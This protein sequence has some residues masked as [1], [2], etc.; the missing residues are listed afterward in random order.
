MKKNIIL[1]TLAIVMVLCTM[2]NLAVPAFAA[3]NDYTCSDYTDCTANGSEIYIIVKDGCPIRE[4][5]HNKGKIVARAEAGQLIAVKRVFWTIK[6]TRWCE[7]ETDSGKSLYVHIDNVEPEV[8]SFITLLSNDNGSVEFCAICGVARAEADGKTAVCDFTCVADQTIRGSFSD[9]NPSFAGILGQI[10]AGEFLGPI[11]DGRDLVGDIMNGE[12]S[13]IIAMDLVAFLPI[14]GALK[15]SDEIA[16][17]GKNGDELAIGAKNVGNI[18]GASHRSKKIF[19]GMWEDYDKV[20]VNGK[21]YAQIGDFKYTEHAVS[22]FLNP[23]IQTN[24]I[25]G[26]EHSRG[27][28][29]SYVNWMLTEGRELGT[30]RVVKEEIKDGIKRITYANGSL[31]V[32]VENG[33]T[34][35]TI[36]TKSK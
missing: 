13:W 30:T 25:R 10:A 21:E 6:M 26:V 2:G 29:P 24:Q 33:D 36:I 34:V 9:Y 18:V 28:P 20:W 11:A 22:E 16:I 7:I 27:V 35:V 1:R 15:Y 5:A 17:L 19:W 14:I 8:H 3:E 4:E 23:S 12:P 32:S 31:W